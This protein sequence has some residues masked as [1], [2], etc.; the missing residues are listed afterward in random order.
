M[1]SWTPQSGSYVAV[2]AFEGTGRGQLSL[3][4]GDVIETMAVSR[5][6][7]QGVNASGQR[8]IFPSSYVSPVAPAPAAVL[9]ASDATDGTSAG[10]VAAGDAG[11]LGERRGDA[12]LL[13]RVDRCLREWCVCTCLSICVPPCGLWLP[14]HERCVLLCCI[15]VKR[16][17]VPWPLGT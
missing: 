7:M 8:G 16:R 13:A 6:W 9:S 1:S 14:H 15:G 2:C 5:G 12:S 11:A 3:A 4:M 17:C 10:V